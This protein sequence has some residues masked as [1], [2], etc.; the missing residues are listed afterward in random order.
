MSYSMLQTTLAEAM[1][2]YDREAREPARITDGRDIEPHWPWMS[3]SGPH[4]SIVHES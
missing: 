4:T 3:R 1:Y 2:E